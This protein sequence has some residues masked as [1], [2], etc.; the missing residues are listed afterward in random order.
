MSDDVVEPPPRARGSTSP[1]PPM[2]RAVSEPEDMI[3]L[4]EAGAMLGVS[5]DTLAKWVRRG[6]LPAIQ[7]GRLGHYRVRRADVAAFREASRLR[8]SVPDD[9]ER[10]S[11]ARVDAV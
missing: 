3:G 7:Y 1:R 2:G 4:T 8:P 10:P 5:R 11:S 9:A 6:R